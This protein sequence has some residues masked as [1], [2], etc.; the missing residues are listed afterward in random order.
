MKL[1]LEIRTNSIEQVQAIAK[2]VEGVTTDAGY[3][4]N[5]DFV[6]ISGTPDAIGRVL[7]LLMIAQLPNTYPVQFTVYDY[8]QRPDGS[9]VAVDRNEPELA[10]R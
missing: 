2:A 10:G 3:R 1:G 5:L 6:E 7:M 4:G 8:E 9:I